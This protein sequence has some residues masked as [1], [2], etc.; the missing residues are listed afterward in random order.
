MTEWYFTIKEIKTFWVELDTNDE[1]EAL[2]KVREMIARGE[3]DLDRPDWYD[4][5]ESMLEV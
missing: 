3:I 2:K 5:D 1:E 4:Y